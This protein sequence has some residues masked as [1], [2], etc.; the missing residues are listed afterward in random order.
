MVRLLALVVTILVTLTGC[1]ST[2]TGDAS[3]STTP[4]AVGVCRML[5]AAEVSRPSNASRAV[6]CSE[7]HDTE[8]FAVGTLPRTLA[9]KAYDDPALDRWAYTTCSAAFSP[10]LGTDEST[11]MRSLLSW[12]W[13][14]PSEAA[15]KRGARWYRCDV[16]G[17]AATQD[18]YVDLPTTTK[19][20]L[21]GRGDDHWMAC[22][23]GR[24]VATSTKVPCSATHNWRAATTIRLGEAGDGYPGDVAVRAKTKTF[25]ADS[26]DAWLGYPS[27]YDYG[28]TWFGEQEWAAGNRR[29]VCWAG[30]MQ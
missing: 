30:T 11:A 28:Y 15:W 14:R 20:L 1:G 2:A 12:I 27:D 4:P 16:L 22:A 9:D 6:A 3:A 5:S 24:S 8:T 23:K 13:F 19:N 25:C 18:R 17:G 21:Q 26:I 7:P 29:S 10:Y